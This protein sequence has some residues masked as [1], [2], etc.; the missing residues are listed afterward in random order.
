MAKSKRI[1][2]IAGEVKPFA[3]VSEVA[4]L[5]RALPEQL[6]AAGNF[7]ARITM[8]RYGTINERRNQL[9]EVIRLSGTDV[10]MGDTTETLTVKVASL[11]DIRLQVYFMDHDGY[12]GRSAVAS[13]DDES[14]FDDNDARTLFFD[15][16]VLETMRKLRWGPDVIHAFGWVSGLVPLLLSSEY[17]GDEHL[18]AAKVVYTPD[19]VDT[20]TTLSESF[21][22]EHGLPTDD[23]DGATLAEAGEHHADAVIY[24]PSLAPTGGHPQFDADAEA[25]AEQLVTLYDE[26]LSEVPA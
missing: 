18:G 4:D 23:L 11:P 17:A 7:E 19:D 15:R 8:P 3:E 10:P 5:A 2:F 14:A 25:R 21:L 1:L 13:D 9:H 26:M 22:A 12:F 24:P 20:T 6:Q 16:A